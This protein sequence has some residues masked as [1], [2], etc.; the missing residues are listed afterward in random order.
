MDPVEIAATDVLASMDQAIADGVNLMSL[1]L[2]FEQSP[3]FEDMI[4]TRALS[5]V[6]K[7]ITVIHVAENNGPDSSTTFNAAPWSAPNSNGVADCP[8]TWSWS[9]TLVLS[10]AYVV[11]MIADLVIE[12]C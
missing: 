6:T 7:E 1:S 8:V 5:A 4:A 2:G 9:S 10:M 12:H 3:Y 11:V